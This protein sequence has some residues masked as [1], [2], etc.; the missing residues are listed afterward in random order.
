MEG[1]S[2]NIFEMFSHVIPKYNSFFSLCRIEKAHLMRILWLFFV[3]VLYVS[4]K[5]YLCF[6]QGSSLPCF[7]WLGN[8]QLFRG[9]NLLWILIHLLA[10]SLACSVLIKF[11]TNVNVL[12]FLILTIAVFQI[13][14]NIFVNIARIYFLHQI[15]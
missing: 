12:H 6:L 8:R 5:M 1:G 14:L 9:V 4:R 2:K 7:L 13:F 11:Y 3:F 10:L 15:L